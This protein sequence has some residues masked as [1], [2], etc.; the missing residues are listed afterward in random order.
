MS[1][2][3]ELPAEPPADAHFGGLQGKPAKQ[4]AAQGERYERLECIPRLSLGAGRASVP[5]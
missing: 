4:E 2:L 1:R 5:G 3:F